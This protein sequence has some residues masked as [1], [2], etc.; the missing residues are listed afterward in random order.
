M[1]LFIS[2]AIYITQKP[3]SEKIV[4][5]KLK[6]KCLCN[7]E[8]KDYSH[9]GIRTG[10]RNIR[11]VFCFNLFFLSQHDLQM[12]LHLRAYIYDNGHIYALCL[13]IVKTKQTHS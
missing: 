11:I 7:V 13:I 3:N 4:G 9:N 10:I 2:I 12:Y 1:W 5:I 6:M 8:N